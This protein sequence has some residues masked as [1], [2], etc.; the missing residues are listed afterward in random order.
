MSGL[1]DSRHCSSP[2]GS[3]T[4][5]CPF[6]HIREYGSHG[7]ETLVERPGHLFSLREYL[8]SGFNAACSRFLRGQS[9]LPKEKDSRH[10]VL[11]LSGV[12]GFLLR[13]RQE[14]GGV[15]LGYR[16]VFFCFVLN[17]REARAGIY[18][19]KA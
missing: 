7:H 18:R 14:S 8:G 19:A 12:G 10:R 13:V 17:P 5:F 1:C 4:P 15:W 11:R 6:S 3:G 16:L 2:W 9:R